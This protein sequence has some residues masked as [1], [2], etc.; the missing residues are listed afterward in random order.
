MLLPAPQ[1]PHP[2]PSASPWALI[3]LVQPALVCQLPVGWGEGKGLELQNSFPT[4]RRSLEKEKNSL[5]NKA[6]NYG[7]KVPFCYQP[8][9]P[10]PGSGGGR[11]PREPT[12]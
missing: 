1:L 6:S 12:G 3:P 7:K 2:Q 8:Y 9:P 10:V 4:H 11:Q 5:M